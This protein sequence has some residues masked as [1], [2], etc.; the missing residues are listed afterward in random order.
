MDEKGTATMN[1]F[2]PQDDPQAYRD[3]LGAFATG[4]TVVTTDSG[5]GPIGITANSFASVSL[6]PPL[7]LWSP[8]KSSKRFDYFATAPHF[9]IHVLDGHQREVCDGFTR[10]KA[11]FDGLDWDL[12]DN[13]TPL[14][15]GCLARFECTLEA[16]HDAGDHVILIGRVKRAAFRSGMPLLFQAGRFVSFKG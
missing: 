6:D 12:D 3:A 10:D 11:A 5:D 1:G 8:A 13:N 7:V 4:V 9:A 14:I 15:S 2:A 16:S